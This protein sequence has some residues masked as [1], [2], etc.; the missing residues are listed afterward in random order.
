MSNSCTVAVALT[1]TCCPVL[2]Y[3]MRYIQTNCMDYMGINMNN[4][5][6]IGTYVLDEG[7]DFLP[8]NR[9]DICQAHRGTVVHIRGRGA[10]ITPD[11]T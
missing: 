10:K 5:D 1:L 2:I 7:V 6:R 11:A 9:V 8:G 3:Y 4:I